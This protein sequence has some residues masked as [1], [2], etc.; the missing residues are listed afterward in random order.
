MSRHPT[1]RPPTLATSPC[2]ASEGASV[3]FVR[4]LFQKPW[5]PA[6]A[7]ADNLETGGTFA[8]PA[9]KVGLRLLLAVV[10]VLF[11]LMIIAYSDRMVLPDWRPLPKPWLLWVSTAILIASSVSFERASIGAARGRMDAVRS[12][13]LWAGVTSGGFLASQLL[14]WR[15]LA[16][17]GYFAETNPSAAFFYLLTAIHGL[18]LLGGLVAWGRVAAKVRRGIEVERL[19]VSLEL[20]AV[21]WHFL[22]AVWLVLFGLL[23]FT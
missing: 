12:H 8:L 19:R 5:M 3:S 23:L 10:T 7:R 2:P 11:S 14:A 16:A 22:L 1:I 6:Q 18:H 20:C 21:Y 4:Q 17:L 15:Q 13:L 9:A